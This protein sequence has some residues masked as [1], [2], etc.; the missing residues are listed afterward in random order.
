MSGYFFELRIFSGV[1]TFNKS[2]WFQ[3]HTD[4]LD[5]SMNSFRF[6][7]CIKLRV[8]CLES[9]VTSCWDLICAIKFVQ[10]VP[11]FCLRIFPHEHLYKSFSNGV[12]YFK[13]IDFKSL[14][15]DIFD[16][17]KY[18]KTLKLT[19]KIIANYWQP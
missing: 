18:E 10:P 14:E 15:F 13:E 3:L 16:L 9:P 7:L 11:F 2:K 8:F 12:K 4:P 17:K 6:L 5:P 1:F 19:F